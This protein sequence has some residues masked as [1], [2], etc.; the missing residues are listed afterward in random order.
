MYAYGYDLAYMFSFSEYLIKI[1]GSTHVAR[2]AFLLFEKLCSR[3]IT[4]KGPP[5]AR[6]SLGE[7]KSAIVKT[8]ADFPKRVQ[9]KL[10]G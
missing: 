4:P 10:F 3:Q 1:Y 2:V 8:V 5:K 6:A 7:G 9:E